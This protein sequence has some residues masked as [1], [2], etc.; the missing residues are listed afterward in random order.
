MVA[1]RRFHRFLF[2][3]FTLFMM[4]FAFSGCDG[5]E[6]PV[7]IGFL[8]GTSGRAA[9]LGISGRDAVQM[10]VDECNR[11]GGIGGRPVRVIYKDDQQD[12]EIAKRAARELVAE[13]VVAVIGPMT[14]DMALAAVP[15]FNEAEIL[16]VSPTA[17]TQALSGLDDYFFRVTSTTEPFARKSARFQIESGDMR[18]IVAIYDE[19]NRSFC[20]NWIENFRRAFTDLGGEILSVIGFKSGEQL[21]FL[22]IARQTLALGPEGVLI[23]ANSMDSAMLCQQ[24]RKMDASTLIT[25][26]DWGATERLLEL[27]G[28]AVEGVTVVQTFNR[29]STAP[30]YLVFRKAYMERYQREPGFPGVYAHDAAKVVLSGL[31]ARQEGRSLKETVLSMGKFEGLQ[32]DFVFDDFGDVKRSHVS[33]SV[34]RNNKFVVVE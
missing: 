15:V 30:Q 31:L 16:V 21:S 2:A 5:K 24:I 11:S 22:E 29:E 32:G 13:S 10:V 19:G 33:I 6:V 7:R 34:V 9:D 28:K 27:G 8:A 26:A 20:E 4:C 14:S 17:T 25:L 3:F 18:R 23:V 12:P 1:H